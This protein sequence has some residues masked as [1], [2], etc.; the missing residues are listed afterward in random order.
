MPGAD[1][2]ALLVLVPACFAA[3]LLTA[4]LRPGP[5]RGIDPD[6][7]A[8]TISVEPIGPPECLIKLAAGMDQEIHYTLDGSEPDRSSP[9]YTEPFEVE[10]GSSTAHLI[11]TPTSVQ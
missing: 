3:C 6:M 8:P 5:E 11:T 4:A 1:L 7:A 2:R 9:L 10:L